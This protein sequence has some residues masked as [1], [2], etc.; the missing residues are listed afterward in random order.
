MNHGI[1]TLCVRLSNACSCFPRHTPISLYIRGTMPICTIT[2][3][4]LVAFHPV[5]FLHYFPSHW[6]R[7]SNLCWW[8]SYCLDSVTAQAII[9][10]LTYDSVSNTHQMPRVV[11]S[12][13]CP[14]R[15]IA[16]LVYNVLSPSGRSFCFP[17]H[18]THVTPVEHSAT[19]S[20]RWVYTLIS[21]SVRLISILL[22][23][24][25]GYLFTVVAPARRCPGSLFNI[26]P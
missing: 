14:C 5:F 23:L 8:R 24:K 15:S 1:R 2:V 16:C 13:K 18:T 19:L 22:L 4:Q 21:C 7:S 11:W 12:A 17:A 25:P 20:T 9:P 10:Q 6:M 3:S 26:L